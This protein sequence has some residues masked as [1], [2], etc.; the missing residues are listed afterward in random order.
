MRRPQTPATSAAPGAAGP[1]D[2][3]RS[4][5]VEDALDVA[6]PIIVGAP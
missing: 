2:G 6:A 4:P 3:R 5:G 1:V